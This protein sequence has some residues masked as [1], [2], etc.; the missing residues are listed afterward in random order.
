MSTTL[1]SVVECHIVQTVPPANLNRDDNGSPKEAYFGGYR[2]S[3]V[4][5]A[6]WKRATRMYFADEMGMEDAQLGIRTKRIAAQLADRLVKRHAV[7][8]AEAGRLATALLAPLGITASSKKAEETSYLFFYGH[9]QLDAIA[10]LAAKAQGL[11]D[12]E[13]EE[14]AKGAGVKQA[15]SE[16]HPLDVALFGR[17]VANLSSIGVEGAVQVAHALSTHAVEL[18]TDYLT[19]VDDA[20]EEDER[21][22]GMIVRRPFNSATLY[23]YAN[24]NVHQLAKTLDGTQEAVDGVL[25]FVEAFAK[26]MPK[27]HISSFAH[28]TVPQLIAVTHRTDQAVNLVTAF[29]SPVRPGADGI[30]SRSV[31]C[32]DDEH[33][34]VTTQWAAPPDWAGHTHMLGDQSLES[35]GER[36]AFPDLLAGLRRR[37]TEVHQ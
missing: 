12:K 8:A 16:K 17:M 33:T 1:R 14:Y 3:R 36:S 19:A 18:E 30:A 34:S 5:D 24:V 11:G 23:R 10:D 37:L 31:Q 13:L 27:G 20:N 4:S 22:A 25:R 15:L 32:L 21:G 35:F 6:A 2:R 9:R 28:R 26:S 7:E 29:E